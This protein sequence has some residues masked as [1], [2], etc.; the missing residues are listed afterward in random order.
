MKTF[1]I[2]VL[3]L[4]L[5]HIAPCSASA[6]DINEIGSKLVSTP[7]YADT[8]LY[9]VLLPSLSEPVK[10]TIALQSAAAPAD[11]LSPCRYLITW[12]LPS[13]SGISSGFSAYFDGSHFR[14]R[15]RRLQEY[16]YSEAADPFAPAGDVSRGVQQ[17]VQFAEILPQFLGLRFRQMATDSS[18][19]SKVT[20]DTL[21]SGKKAVVIEGVR[22]AGGYDALEYTYVLRP[23]D[24]LPRSIEYEMNPG[25]I[26][27]QNVVIKFAEAETG[28]ECDISYDRLLA[29]QPEAFEKY[30][31]NTF[32][33]S[34]LPGRPLP[35]IAAPTKGGERYIHEREE[36]LPAPTVFSFIDA[37]VSSTPEVI[38][39][40]RK[41]IDQL[42][43]QTDAVWVLV[44]HNLDEGDSIVGKLR[45]GELL[46]V[47]AGAAARDCGVG[48]VTPALIFVATDGIVT[49]VQIGYNKD[50]DSIVI[51]KATNSKY[52][53]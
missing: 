30:R 43:F 38:E 34:T 36:A 44:N 49:D 17:Q 26:G 46:L 51:Q 52:S 4:A 15:D 10:Y 1:G 32:S 2:I 13:P 6:L 11:T 35:R 20:A 47:N 53:L 19:I 40:V 42:P 33:L 3:A 25:Q 23:G 37:T 14:Y 27:E 7:C 5:T 50:L 28:Q 48:A 45:P 24:F 18:Y 39:N 31:E 8:V 16:H 9:D 41:A 21:V 12:S 29:A 22:R